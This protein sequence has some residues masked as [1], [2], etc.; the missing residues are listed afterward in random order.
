MVSNKSKED[1][2]LLSLEIVDDSWVLDF[3]A[4]FHA[5]PHRGYFIDYFQGDFGL[6]YLG[7]N[8]PYHIFGPKVKIKL[9]NGNHWL[10]HEVN[11]FQG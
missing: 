1:D 4:S 9:Q 8:E 5:T 7:D 3:G 10:L 6:F 2:F 11:M